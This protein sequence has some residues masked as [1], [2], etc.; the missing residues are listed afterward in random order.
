MVMVRSFTAMT[1]A[2]SFRKLCSSIML[3][4]TN[5]SP[6]NGQVRR[7]LTLCGQRFVTYKR[8]LYPMAGGNHG[9]YCGRVGY[10]PGI[11]FREVGCS[12]ITLRASFGSVVDWFAEVHRRR[13]GGDQA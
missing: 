13:S 12:G 4:S 2:Y 5:C 1:S 7:V 11:W 9:V 6:V 3:V 10:V 8:V